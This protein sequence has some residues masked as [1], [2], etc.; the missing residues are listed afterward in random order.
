MK[1]NNKYKGFSPFG[2]ASEFTANKVRIEDRIR[3]ALKGINPDDYLGLKAFTVKE[4]KLVEDHSPDFDPSNPDA[5]KNEVHFIHYIEP[6]GKSGRKKKLSAGQ[7]NA[8]WADMYLSQLDTEHETEDES[9]GKLMNAERCLAGDIPKPKR[10]VE[11]MGALDTLIKSLLGTD[12][13]TLYN[14]LVGK[15]LHPILSIKTDHNNDLLVTYED[16]QGMEKTKPL[17]FSTIQNKITN[18]KK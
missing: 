5:S 7:T 3:R 9:W 6:K 10:Q 16:R 11:Y 18:I 1:I 12:A 4:G 15:S 14:K 8:I 17:T 2:Y 13:D